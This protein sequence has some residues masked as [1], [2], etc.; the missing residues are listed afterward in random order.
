MTVRGSEI[1]LKLLLANGVEA[2][3]EAS[4]SDYPKKSDGKP[5]SFRGISDAAARLA[6]VSICTGERRQAAVSTERQSR[7][8]KA[9]MVARE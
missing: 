2:D 9:K 3:Y 7:G 8:S 5:S 6:K 4:L 1:T